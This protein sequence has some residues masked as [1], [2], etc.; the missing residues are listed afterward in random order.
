MNAKG[1]TTL[2]LASALAC[3]GA[4]YLSWRKVSQSSELKLDSATFLPIVTAKSDELVRIDVTTATYK[5][6]LVRVGDKWVARDRGDYP[7]RNLAVGSLITS[8][9]AMRPIEPKTNNPGSFGAIGVSD[10]DTDKGGAI[11]N[12]ALKDGSSAG[13]VIIGKRSSAMSFDP[14]GGTFVRQPG[15]QQAWLVQGT[16]ALPFEFAGWFDE[17]PNYPAPQVRRV[18]IS[19][20]G[21]PVFDAIK[22]NDFYRSAKTEEGAPAVFDYVNDSMVK[23]VSAALVSGTFEDI[24]PI[25]QMALGPSSRQIRF[26]LADGLI[27]EIEVVEAG[28]SNYL[29]FKADAAQGSE[30]ASKA[31]QITDRHTG[32]AY[33]VPTSRINALSTSVEEL[34]TRPPDREGPP[35]PGGMPPG[36]PQGLPNGMPQGGMPQGFPQGLPPEL[37]QQLPPEVLQ[38]LQQQGGQGM[39][40]AMPTGR[41]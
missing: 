5:L 13:G 6:Q 17:T 31:K 16:A 32:W 18:R 10:S 21:K 24:K 15:N 38:S 30:A 1:F 36:L 23:K 3:A 35:G 9:A 19:E 27:I 29:R 37:L 26:D 25:G 40:Q 28:G 34:T 12:F 33:K 7:L 20:N 14:L 41:Q 8:I 11:L 2:L 4:G 39:P 22:D